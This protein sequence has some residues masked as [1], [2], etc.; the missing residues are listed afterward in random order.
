MQTFSIN[1]PI[2]LSDESNWLLGVTSFEASNS[3]FNI[4]DEN[5]SFSIRIPCRW[6]IP[7]YLEDGI[8]DKQ[9][10]LLKFRSQNDIEIHVK[11][12]RKKGA[13]IKTKAKEYNL[14]DFDTFKRELFEEMKSN[15]YHNLQN[16][17][18]RI[19]LTFKEVIDVWHIKYFPSERKGY[20]CRRE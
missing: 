3:V 4:T 18:Y 8:I 11:E 2:N 1:T 5:N 19:G 14:P 9:N 10:K 15:I 20:I 16:Y 13:Q 7:N 6:R 12:V 17:V